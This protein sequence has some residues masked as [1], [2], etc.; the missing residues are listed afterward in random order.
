MYSSLD[1]EAKP[2]HLA[3]IH[4]EQEILN[5]QSQCRRILTIPVSTVRTEVSME[6]EFEL[7]SE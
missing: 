7:Q 5:S 2:S 1:I 4:Q 6:K 3:T